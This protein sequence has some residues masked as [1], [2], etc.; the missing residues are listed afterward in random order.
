MKNMKLI[1]CHLAAVI[2]FSGLFFSCSQTH[3]A[4]EYVDYVNV[5]IGTGGH[6]HTYPGATLPHG[7]VQ[8]SPDTRLFGWDGCS[9]YYYADSSIIGFSHTH[10]SGTGIGDYGD[11]L[12]MPTS[13]ENKFMVSGNAEDPDSGYRS[14]FSHKEEEAVPGITKSGCPIMILPLS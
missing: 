5:F 12:M 4:K 6:G 13:G 8:L 1:G 7:M 10:L 2:V 11:I 14:R 9:G 3:V